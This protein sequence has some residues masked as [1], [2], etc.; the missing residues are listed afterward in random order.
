MLSFSPTKLIVDTISVIVQTD[1]KRRKKR[2]K[3][4]FSIY[5]TSCRFKA[6]SNSNKYK[7]IKQNSSLENY[8]AKWW[9]RTTDHNYLT[10]FMQFQPYLFSPCPVIWNISGRLRNCMELSLWEYKRNTQICKKGNMLRKNVTWGAT[11]YIQKTVLIHN[12][13]IAK[14][15]EICSQRIHMCSSHLCSLKHF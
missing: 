9:P 2:E 11:N 6:N 7:I 5:L 8:K 3:N 14:E 4:Y 13:Q 1:R 15:F 10:V 12:H